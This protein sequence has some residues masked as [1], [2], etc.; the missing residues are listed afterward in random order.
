MADINFTS[1]AVMGAFLGRMRLNSKEAIGDALEGAAEE[2]LF[3]ARSKFGTYQPQVGPFPAWAPLQ[4]S[5]LRRRQQ[6][7]INPN[8]E[9]LD[10]TGDLKDSY[11]VVRSGLG[12]VSIGSESPYAQ[13]QETGE[14]GEGRL[15]HGIPPRPVLGPAI[16]EAA[17]KGVADHIRNIF[18][19]VMLNGRRIKVL[20][21]RAAMDSNITPS[22]GRG[23]VH[24]ADV[25]DG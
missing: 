5:T 11:E 14:Y 2:V 19:D 10:E 17:D 20:T 18:V 23:I 1:F 12:E 9:P 15:D 13:V 16:I 22:Y 24:E 21:S 4:E 8:D 25:F 6:R 3:I 7:G